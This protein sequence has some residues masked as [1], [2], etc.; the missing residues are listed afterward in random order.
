M[1]HWG[2]LILGGAF[3][4][5]SLMAVDGAWAQVPPS[6]DQPAAAPDRWPN[7]SLPPSPTAFPHG[8]GHYLSTLKLVLVI[9]LFLLWVKTTDWVGQDTN[10]TSLNYA[11]WDP[12]VFAPFMVAFLLL[13]MVPWFIV[14]YLVMV[15]AWA[16]PLG[17]YVV[18]RN[19]IVQEHQKVM[20]PGHLRHVFAQAMG[21]VG[22]KIASE[23]QLAHQK[24]A[25]VHFK[26]TA[27]GDKDG[28]ANLLLARRSPGYVPTKDLFAELIDRVGNAALLEVTPQHVAVRYQIDGVWHNVEPR[29]REPGE[30]MVAVLKTIAGA[31]ANERVKRQ[32]GNFAAEYNGAKFFARLQ[33]Q[34]ADGAERVLINLNPTKVPIQ[35]LEEL[36]MRPKT[37]EKLKELLSQPRGFVIFSAPPGGGLSS[38]FDGALKACDRYMRDF[39]SIEDVAHR[40]HD[41]EN[42]HVTTYNA[43]AGETPLPTLQKVIRTYP[44]VLVMRHLPNAET[45]KFLC[46]QVQEDRLIMTA[47]RAKDAAESVLRVMMLKAPPKDLVGAATGAVCVRLIRKLCDQCK[48]PYPPP[49]ELLKQLGLPPGK[50]Q[51]FFRPPSEPDPKKPC[52]NCQ[53]IGY[54]GRTGMFELLIVDDA[55]REVLMKSPKLDLVRAAARKGGMKTFQDEGLVLVVKG[56]TSMP[57]LQRAL[58]G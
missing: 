5:A 45:V 34:T 10:R 36:G 48:E 49:Q 52:P 9:A 46:D 40:E 50:V 3:L 43:A 33:S 53:G 13:L 2:K 18:L 21:M 1:A 28:E 31:D 25:P 11:V 26:A 19:K 22:V 30:M 39:A 8:P 41:I 12:V 55:V 17:T 35:T 29:E 27:R 32:E 44:N 14:G 16:I 4:T 47:V 7:F 20:T 56:V 57:E 24:G 42:V 51:A 38:L 15:F 37:Q 54:K 23:R 6:P 58:Q